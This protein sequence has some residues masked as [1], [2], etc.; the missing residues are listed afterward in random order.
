MLAR[1]R[2]NLRSTLKQVTASTAA[3]LPL[4]SAS[5]QTMSSWAR[6]VQSYA[7][8]PDIFQSFFEP[9]LAAGR[10]F[11][12]TVLTP[13]FEGFLFRT[14]EKLI[15]DLGD[16]II[17]LERNS[18]SFDARCYPLQGIIHVEVRTILLDTRIKI[19]GLTDSGAPAASTLR[20]NTV[21]DYLFTPILD[22]I[23]LAKGGSTDAIPCSDSEKFNHWNKSNFKF[24]NYARCSILEG[25]RVFQ[26][27]L[28]PEIRSSQVTILGRTFY[29]TISPT[30]ACI[31]TD[32]EFIIIREDTRQA[33][34][35]RYGGIWDYIPLNKISAISLN[36]REN[37]LLVLSIQLPGFA[38]LEYLFRTS[39][40]QE[41]DELLER[42]R[43]LSAGV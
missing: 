11:P 17:V 35:Q 37:R 8:V 1:V 38:P 6:P 18:S 9:F 2:Y 10:E 36:E 14:G 13:A 41:I 29:R 23:R 40:K 24:M 4:L 12:Y 30:L 32:R 20:I 3:A 43:E 28:Q 33:G 34:G 7:A 25:E 15:C 5:E 16:T 22:R 31:L 21:C 27:I 19:S 39:A 42:Y 26:A